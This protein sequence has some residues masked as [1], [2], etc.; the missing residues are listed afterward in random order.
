MKRTISV[1]VA[2][3]CVLLAFTSCSKKEGGASGKDSSNKLVVWS[4]TDELGTM[5]TDYF[6]K[7]VRF[8]G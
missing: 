7:D 1:L 8:A 4:F 2:L 5:I 3:A 6:Q